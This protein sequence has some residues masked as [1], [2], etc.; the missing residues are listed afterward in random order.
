MADLLTHERF[1]RAIPQL[2]IESLPDN[3]KPWVFSVSMAFEEVRDIFDIYENVIQGLQLRIHELESNNN[4]ITEINIL[5]KKIF[6]LQTKGDA[7]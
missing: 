3:V 5:K 2:D 7:A 6:D 1:T 4:L